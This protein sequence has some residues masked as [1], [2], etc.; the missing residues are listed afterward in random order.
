MNTLILNGKN[1]TLD[2]LYE[3][4]HHNRPVEIAPEAYAR[5]E[6]G[7]QIMSE[8]SRQGKPIYGFNRGVGQNKDVNIDEDFFDAQNRMILRSH[9]LG[10][11]PFNTDVEV[12]AMMCI[13]LNNMLIGASCASDGLAN[14]YRDFLNHGITP[15][16]PK[17]G[18]VGEADITT[19]AHMGLAFIGEADVSYKG[20]IVNAKAAMDAEGIA[21]Y[22][23]KLKDA[24][25]IILS[26]CQ[27]E[28]MAAI[29]AHEVEKLVKL[30]DLIFCLD[31]EG[32]NGNIESMRED[33]NELRG[34]AGQIECA[35]RCRKYLENSYLHEPHPD[36]ALQ[37]PLTFRGGFTITGSVTDAI[38]FVKQF[39]NIQINSPSD[40]P[41]IMPETG[42][43]L[44]NSNF[45]T[46]SLV[47]AVEMLNIAL[48]HLSR[49]VAYRMI[50]M[51][52]P[53]FTGLTRFLAPR[54][55]SAHG[56]STIQNSYMV[57]DAENR[58]LVNPSSMDFFPIEGNIEDHASNLP[59]AC[60]KGLKMVDN[61]RYLVGMEALYAAQAVDL[62][63]DIRLGRA[64]AAAY[65]TIREIIPTLGAERIVYDD[66]REAYE[67]VLSGKLLEQLDG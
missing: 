27:G 18:A 50:K 64:T 3:V 35:A 32:L 25:T 19:I 24:H 4:A 57:M 21:P 1:L 63:G 62:R 17:R 42:E 22:S 52:S 20:Q 53:D 29:M 30:S 41:C 49:A 43:V 67:L 47:L 6:K 60:S 14:I 7:R 55:G 23:L 39:L 12:R 13:R 51:S 59:L 61:I 37:D 10:I 56:Y 15:R 58:R 31:Y 65:R 38:N 34:L 9:S 40:N 28:A 45:E 44:V 46:T 54:D 2:D 26:N 33:V 5:L 48:G 36:R 8:L 66:I 16:I 11:P